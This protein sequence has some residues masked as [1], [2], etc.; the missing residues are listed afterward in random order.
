MPIFSHSAT[1]KFLQWSNF[2]IFLVNKYVSKICNQINIKG[3]KD[4][5]KLKKENLI[6]NVY[7]NENF[8]GKSRLKTPPL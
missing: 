1:I 5:E 7:Y 4:H 8:K 3:L 6:T 2:H